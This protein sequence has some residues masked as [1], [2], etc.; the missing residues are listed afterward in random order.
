MKR[1]LAILTIMVCLSSV[2]SAYANT[3]D[4][5][6]YIVNPASGVN[7]RDARR[8]GNVIT[9]IR[10]GEPVEVTGESNNWYTVRLNDGTTGYIYKDYL[11]VGHAEELEAIDNRRN[12]RVSIDNTKA[13]F[14]GTILS[15]CKV[16]KKANGKVIGEYEAG[17]SVYIR[18]TGKF[19]HK[20]V[21]N[22]SEIG[23]IQAKYVKVVDI[24]IPGEGTVYMLT[25]QN[26]ET[27]KYSIRKEPSYKSKE[28]ALFKMGRYVRVL[29]M[30]NSVWAKVVYNSNGDIGY[31]RRTWL[32]KSQRYN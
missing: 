11:H 31:V 30:V 13:E 27:T 23:Y 12:R 8:E 32:Q 9:V 25:D 26:N 19:W 21:W 7:V 17:D 3:P 18:Q 2:C 14:V 15:S 29:E 1:V 16:Y 4:S 6:T 5:V 20:I 10:G 24:N 28:L 22:N